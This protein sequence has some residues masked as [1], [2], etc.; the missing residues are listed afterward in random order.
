M[1]N[2]FNKKPHIRS[3]F[4]TIMWTAAEYVKLRKKSIFEFDLYST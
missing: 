3:P 2:C 4:T 1:P